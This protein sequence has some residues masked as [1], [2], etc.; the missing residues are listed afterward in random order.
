[1]TVI[2]NK[3]VKSGDASGRGTVAGFKVPFPGRMHGY[4][5]EAV[6]AVVNVMRNTECQ[7]QGKYL[8]EFEAA[9][10]DYSGANHAFAVDNCTN[11]LRLAAILCG[12]K[13]GD[14]VI[15]SA[16][17]F[18][19]TAIPFGMTGA[20]IVWADIDEKRRVA[21]PK[22]IERKITEKT[23]AIVVVHL[24]GMPVDM[25]EIL[26]IAQKHNLRV[27]ED[28][29]QA[30]GAAIDG[31]KVGTFGDFGCFSWHGAKNIT[32]LGEGGFL[33][34]RSDD[35][36]KL[37]PGIRHNGCRGFEGERERYWV[38]AMS[39]V[40]IDIP[41]VWPN[42]F[43]IGEA[44]CAAG[45]E[46]LK[47]LDEVNAVLIS[48][49]EKLKDL[50]A[51]VEEISFHEIPDGYKMIYHQFVMH[52]DGSAFGKD[53]NDLMDILVND[54]KIRA[55]VQY[56]PL[57][58]YPLFQKLGAGEHDCPVLEKWWDN[59]FSFP[60]WCGMDD[61]TLEYLVSSLKTAIAKLK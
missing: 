45:I 21:D 51:D 30:P 47:T 9:F 1:M 11:A 7:T 41:G 39:T 33:T 36:A 54:Y 4:S 60:W 50:L 43:C 14:E 49:G 23:K 2:K 42:N 22:D 20:K 8:G 40:D 35:D 28:C 26:K 53:R 17:T 12:L 16:Y 19:A 24:L 52:F 48:Q 5:E 32:T 56:Y 15:I 31:K 27:V 61:E 18:C 25:P 6:N 3:T 29:A 38:P 44:Q 57:Y 46:E 34:V 10:K 37:V 13:A 55:I 58:R 59:S